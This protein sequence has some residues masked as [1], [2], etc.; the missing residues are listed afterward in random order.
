MESDYEEKIEKKPQIY[1]G[2]YLCS[3]VFF[4]GFVGMSCPNLHWIASGYQL[5]TVTNRNSSKYLIKTET[6]YLNF[7]L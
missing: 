7:N 3:F 5:S 2:L 1:V 6:V 4:V